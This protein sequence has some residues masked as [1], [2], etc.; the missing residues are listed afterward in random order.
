SQ[1]V[2]L[3]GTDP[4]TLTETEGKTVELFDS[5]SSVVS[6]RD[7]L[8]LEGDPVTLT[9]FLRKSNRL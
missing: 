3:K 9:S 5:F 7:L 1:P 8:G 2:A 6:F 4:D